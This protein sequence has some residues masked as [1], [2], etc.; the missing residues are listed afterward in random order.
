[1]HTLII[2]LHLYIKQYHSNAN[3]VIYHVACLHKQ[4]FIIPN[5]Y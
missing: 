5:H 4:K 2:T 1:M 3:K